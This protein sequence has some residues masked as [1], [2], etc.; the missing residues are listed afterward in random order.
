MTIQIDCTCRR[1]ISRLAALFILPMMALTASA[2]TSTADLAIF[3]T[4]ANP[5]SGVYEFIITVVNNGP[6]PA[7][8]V[9]LIDILPQNATLQKVVFNSK[10]GVLCPAVATGGSVTCT[11]NSPLA[12]G[13]GFSVSFVVN[14]AG[15]S[16]TQATDTATVTATNAAPETQSETITVH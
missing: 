11:T 2:Q 14:L 5:N 4:A 3:N 15:L 13:A 7:D 8:G 6:V 1:K 10:K 9:Q 16:G 12:P